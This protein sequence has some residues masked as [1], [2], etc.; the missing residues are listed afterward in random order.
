[1]TINCEVTVKEL[2]DL[3]KEI[4]RNGMPSL[5]MFERINDKKH[6]AVNSNFQSLKDAT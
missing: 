4:Q 5:E 2:A 6:Y 3:L 1:M